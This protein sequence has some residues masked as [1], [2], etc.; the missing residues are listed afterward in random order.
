M[1]GTNNIF[2]TLAFKQFGNWQLATG[3]WQLATG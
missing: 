3:N 2:T 1:T